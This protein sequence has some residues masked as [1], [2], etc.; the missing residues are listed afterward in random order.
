MTGPSALE[1]RRRPILTLAI[2]SYLYK[3]NPFYKLAE[4]LFVGIGD[5]L[6][7]LPRVPDGPRP[8]P[9]PQAGAG[10]T[11]V[12]VIP[13]VL[14]LLLFTRLLPRIAWLSRWSIG[15]M[16]GAFSGPRR[17]RLPAERASAPRSRR[18][19]VSVNTGDPAANINN[20]VLIAGLVAS[21]IYFFFSA[22]HRG[23]LGQGRRASGSGS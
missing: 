10:D 15:L 19:C 18:T 16:V 21:L 8:E 6:L 13:L 2:F 17:D 12:L 23:A 7:A 9:L 3:D 11:L 4:H 1:H 5:R 14:G 22:E 20:S